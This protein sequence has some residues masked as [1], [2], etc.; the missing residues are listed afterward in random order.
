M[1][2]K[3]KIKP[4]VPAEPIVKQAP[5][6]LVFSFAELRPFSYIEAK[7]D[8]KFFIQF[9]ERLQKLGNIDWNTVNTSG[10]HSFGTEKMKVTDLTASA[11]QLVP[12]GVESLIVLRATGS[13]H[14]FLG[15]RHENVFYVIF[16]EYQFGD[17]YKH[18][19]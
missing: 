19:H 10:R 14:A 17:I 15:T 13:N 16:I 2:N 12:A 9:L 6:N 18:S 11:R 4:Q 7:K 8:G 5:L 1:G 3:F